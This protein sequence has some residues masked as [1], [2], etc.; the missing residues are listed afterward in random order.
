MIQQTNLMSFLTLVAF[1]AGAAIPMLMIALFGQDM[2]E[3]MHYFKSHGSLFRKILGAIIILGVV[4]SVHSEGA[5]T[6]SNQM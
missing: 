2:M 6:L 4:Y 1:G 5:L 3:K